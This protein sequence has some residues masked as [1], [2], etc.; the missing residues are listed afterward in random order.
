[1]R[2]CVI[3][4]DLL[5]SVCVSCYSAYMEVKFEDS[6]TVNGLAELSPQRIDPV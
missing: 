4:R 3:C 1:M 5:S 6:Q 2:Q